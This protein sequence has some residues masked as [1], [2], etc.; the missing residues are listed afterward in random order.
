MSI[1]IHQAICLRD[2]YLVLLR[3]EETGRTISIDAPDAAAITAAL[4]QKEWHLTDIL[5]THK[6]HDHVGGIAALRETFGCA[7][8]APTRAKIDVPD[9]DRYCDDGDNITIG[10]LDFEAMATPGHCD[11]HMAY[12]SRRKALLFAGDA[13]FAMGCGRVLEG[14]PEIL[15]HSLMRLADLPDET[16]VYCGHEYTV[17]NARFALSVDGTNPDIAS[18][19]AEV[20]ALRQREAMT[21]PTTIGLEKRT[22]VFLRAGSAEKF[23]ALREAKNRF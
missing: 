22:N 6:H 18:R 10:N 12:Y 19:T 4:K 8:I 1:A 11:D 17:A 2:N 3:D 5:V 20:E 15:Y 23:V 16:S 14:K 21:L 7:V 9:A 13:L